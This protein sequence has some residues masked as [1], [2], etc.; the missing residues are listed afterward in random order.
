M[1]NEMN[2]QWTG[3]TPTEGLV[4]GIMLYCNLL[5]EEKV[6]DMNVIMTEPQLPS[7]F[8]S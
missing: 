2:G 4:V 5:R 1:W 8:S 6:S 7:S 3:N